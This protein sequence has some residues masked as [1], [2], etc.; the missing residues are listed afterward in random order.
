MIRRSTTVDA[1]LAV[2]AFVLSLGVLAAD[3]FGTPDASVHHLDGIGV[4]VTAMTALPL[5]F[6]A[7]APMVVCVVTFAA[8]AVLYRFGYPFDLPIGPGIAIYTLGMAYGGDPR[9][10]HR[11][12]ALQVALAFAPL[13]G[14]A[15]LLRGEDVGEILVPELLGVAL[16]AATLYLAGDRARMRRERMAELEE[17]AR[18]R[19]ERMAELEEQARRA[20][21]D[22]ER[23][24]RLAVAEERT[25]I[26][27]ELHDS[28]GH[29]I[30]VI[31]VQAGAARL[32]HE[33]DPAGSRR[34][35]T[36]IEDVAR[37]TIGEIDRLVRA[38]R[39]DGP[40]P[41]APADPTALAE[42]VERHRASGLAI[43]AVI[44]PP[45]RT[46]PH[47]VA[48]AAYRILQEALTNAARH[49]RGSADVAVRF[50]PGAVDITVTNPTAGTTPAAGTTAVTG[51][52][53]GIV[54]MRERATLLGGTL[55]AAVERG[56]FR[57]HAHLPHGQPA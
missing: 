35:I 56:V 43:A 16:V 57:L 39:D 47:G 46:L 11:R 5:V 31:L 2:L 37:G 38:L 3:G 48:W 13:L 23:E 34:A 42:L 30:N 10:W 40:V 49:G 22:A 24:R 20:G 18:M 8:S 4:L 15:Y 45:G 26:A 32:L 19:R 7:R 50:A 28:A 14:F 44:P 54:G 55:D 52:G 21:R 33:R 17:Q 6:R 51:G 25:R 1:G 29:A 27:R 41:P 36:A 9:P 12:L 53:H